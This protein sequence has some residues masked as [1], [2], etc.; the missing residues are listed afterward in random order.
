MQFRWFAFYFFAAFLRCYI[1]AP[2]VRAEV[3]RAGSCLR[4]C[5]LACLLLLYFSSRV[6]LTAHQTAHAAATMAEE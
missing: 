6:F 3:E 1:Q 5:V 2:L 4:A